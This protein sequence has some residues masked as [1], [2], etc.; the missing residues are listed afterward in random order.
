MGQGYTS[1]AA[2]SEDGTLIF[3]YSSNVFAVWDTTGKQN[4][5]KEDLGNGTVAISADGRWL[6]AA[7]VNSGTSVA[8]WNV[9]T[10]LEV[11]GIRVSANDH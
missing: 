11:C 4:C 10:A 6:A 1:F 3:T 2:F 5:Y 7:M 8:I 9:R